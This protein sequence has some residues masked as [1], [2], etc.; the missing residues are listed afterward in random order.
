MSAIRQCCLAI[1]AALWAG[2][3][4]GL[5][6]EVRNGTRLLV[7]LDAA[8]FAN[9]AG[10]WPQHSGDTGIPGHFIPRGSPTRQTVAGAPAVVFD[11]DGDAFVGPITTAALHSAGAPYSV[12]VWAFQGNIREQESLVSWGRRGGPDATFA[13][14]RYGADPEFGAVA[15][16]GPS[17][18][19]Y[20]KPPPPGRWHQLVFTYDGN[21]MSVYVDGQADGV[22]TV[23]AL[24]PHDTLP[25]MLGAELGGDGQPEGKFTHFSGALGLVRIHAGV[26]DA[27]EVRRRF[28]CDAPSFSGISAAPLAGLPR[29]RYSFALTAGNA[30]DGTALMDSLGGATAFV[31]GAGAKFTGK[32]LRLPGGSSAESAYLDFPNRI[33]SAGENVT[34]EM[35]VTQE[36]AL[37][38]GRILSIGTNR[39]GEIRAPGGRFEGSETLTLFGNVGAA[40]VNRFA[41]SEGLL[42]NGGPDRDPADYPASEL[43][44]EFHHAILYEKALSEWRWYRNGI[45]ME[46]IPDAEGPVTLDDVNVWLGRSEFSADNNLR[47]VYREFRVYNRALAEGEIFGN[48]R[49]GPDTLRTVTPVLAGRWRGAAQGPRDFDEAENW[50]GNAVPN[51]AGAVA[52]ITGRP[53]GEQRI[54]LGSRISLGYLTLGSETPDGAYT[55]EAKNAGRLV[56]D[57]GSGG[58]AA[59]A[60]IPDS[61][62]TS[63]A[64]PLEIPA[65]AEIANLAKSPL[66]LAGP[67]SGSGTLVK[68]GPGPLFLTGES[69]GFQGAARILTGSLVIGHGNGSGSLSA[70]RFS[71]AR[72][73]TLGVNRRDDCVLGV[74][75]DGPGR[76]AQQGTGRLTLDDSAHLA[77]TGSVDAEDG[78]GPLVSMGTIDGAAMVK[79]DSELV[80][81]AHSNTRVREH[82]SAGYHNG[83]R[84]T[85][86]DGANVTLAGGEGALNVGDGGAGQSVLALEGG[87]VFWK[88]LYVGKASG[89][90]GVLLQTGGDLTRRGG[91]AGDARIGGAFE[92]D[93]KV[94][95]AWQMK[96]GTFSTDSNLQIG[97]YGLGYLE[98]DG[99]TAVVKGF[100]GVGRYQD[101]QLNKSRG[102]VDVRSGRLST[103]APDKLLTVGEEGIGV[104]NIRDRGTVLCSNRMIIGGGS[105]TAAGR[106]SVN[107][108]KGGTLIANGI[109]QFNPAAA[110][111]VLY[112]DGGSV[113]AG[114]P[115]ASFVEDLDS[116]VIGPGGA[117]FDT[118][119]HEVAIAQPLVAPLGNG[120]RSI[121]V[122]AGGG[123]YLVPPIVEISGGGGSGAVAVAELADGKVTGLT[124]VNPGTGYTSPP[125]VSILGGGAGAGVVVG[126]PE[127]G[128]NHGGGLTKTGDGLLVL[129]GACFYP[130]A[131]VVTGGELRINGDFGSAKGPVEVA[132]GATLSGGGHLGGGVRIAAGGVIA[133]G[134]HGGSLRVDGDAELR[135]TLRPGGSDNPAG[136]LEVKGSLDLTGS[137]VV[138]ESTSGTGRD[139]QV[140]ATYGTLLGKFASVSVPKGFVIDY[141]YGGRN[142]IA[143]IS[144]NHTDGN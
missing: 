134:P 106:G 23:G 42:L 139:P 55:L 40:P 22:K 10:H 128:A 57:A 66:V 7:D 100:L 140:I 15:L 51:G 95:G 131:T 11:G 60:Q 1:A 97:A 3:G 36:A 125:G 96:G 109:G 111:G 135:G 74:A 62:P 59:L 35:W 104:L 52:A 18:I 16:W 79:S 141:Q 20:H 54:V 25:I 98:I 94:W 126:T 122:E 13:G 34:I 82:L 61:L 90:S 53:K 89:T 92:G 91:D 127:L 21:R 102:V 50:T 56:L 14:F 120:V 63:V 118:N 81:D 144:T 116:V 108:S 136:T 30:P 112:F 24:D 105:L 12:E 43:G 101:A 64:V 28:E 115:S 77:L 72:N 39:A 49:N 73:A 44:E 33:V 88:E 26:L 68:T 9:G 75:A 71:V 143:L 113:R 138:V 67:V 8:D 65:E 31:R 110:F 80:L 76:F 87:N 121:P 129:S 45:L 142:E 27:G 32:G 5:A 103:S 29:H 123:G 86:R 107:L 47:G 84:I 46:V 119:G 48:W 41:R 114:A 17:E 93:P 124:I 133:P 117:V 2:A 37:D 38:W 78:S 83:G 132:K 99:G 19:G 6:G 85:I 70:S 130:G 137:A 58:P 69:V 4:S